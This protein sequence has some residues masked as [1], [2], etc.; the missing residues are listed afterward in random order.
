[1]VGIQADLAAGYVD[2]LSTDSALRASPDYLYT[3]GRTTFSGV[4]AIEGTDY[5]DY[6][7]GGTNTMLYGTTP[8]E[9][10]GPRGGADTVDGR[11]GYDIVYYTTSPNPIKVDMRLGTGQVIDDGWGS[12]DTLIG[13]ERVEGSHFNDSLV[14]N[15]ADNNDFRGNRGADTIDGGGGYDEL[16]YFTNR[17][18]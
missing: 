15:D 14:G 11:S 4:A 8:M 5:A 1:M 13:V 7:A 9:V 12:T 17:L 10:F 18:T 16:S 6:I 3:V 2:A